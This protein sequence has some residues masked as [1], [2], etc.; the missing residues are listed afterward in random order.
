MHA[1]IR[2][3]TWPS[4]FLIFLNAVIAGGAIG[5][6]IPLLPDLAAATGMGIADAAWLISGIA[7]AAVVIAPFGG[8]LADRFGDRWLSGIGIGVMV[9][10]NLL[11]WSAQGFLALLAARLVE[12]V[13][14]ICLSL[15]AT[16]MMIR[17]THGERQIKAMALMSTGVP[18]GI[19][20]GVALAGQVAGE[21]WRLVFPVHAAVLAVALAGLRLVPAWSRP[22]PHAE[23]RAPGWWSVV[24]ASGPA[25]LALGMLATSILAF[26]LGALF[27]TYAARAFDLSPA[28]AA[29]YGLLSY[30]ASVIGSLF[31][32][33]L[34]T[35]LGRR[36]MLLLSFGL[37]AASGIGSYLPGLGIGAAVGLLFV[38]YVVCGMAGAIGMAQ[39]PSVVPS[40]AA[41]GVTTGLFIQAG[42]CGTLLGT[43]LTVLA[44]GGG[45]SS[46]LAALTLAC[47]LVGLANW[48]SLPDRAG[49]VAPA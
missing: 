7:A 14:F 17:T 21:G 9:A 8:T 43:P 26:G 33:S 11:G 32:G 31:V 29:T 19:G 25:R 49:G 42:N 37:L 27:P 35:R 28:Q 34:V 3:G 45:A 4:I 5:K 44:Y 39:L 2:P 23:Q 22:S 40:P 6:F 46:G 1:P 38:F 12:G 15:G 16:A 36:A 13:G 18:L 47:A 41:M 24:S 10:A 30:P 20:L 48:Y